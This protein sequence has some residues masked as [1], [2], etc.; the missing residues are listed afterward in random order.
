MKL[1]VKGSVP[2]FFVKFI[3]QQK[4]KTWNE[5]N[6]IRKELRQHILEEQGNCCAY[7]EVRLNGE[8]SCHIDHYCTRNLFPERTFDYNNLLVSCNSEEYAAK[9]K[10]KQIKGKLD[11]DELINPI[12]DRPSD[13]IEFAFTGDVLPL[14]F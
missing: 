2:D 8:E 12:K 4:P 10:D 13:Y 3:A 9:Y 14:I 1:I 11:Y 7:T 5:L 6:S